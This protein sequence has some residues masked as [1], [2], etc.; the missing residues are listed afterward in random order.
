MNRRELLSSAAALL[1]G[2]RLRAAGAELATHPN[3]TIHQAREAGLKALKPTAGQIQRGLELHA[4]ALVFDAYAFAPRAAVDGPALARAVRAGASDAELQDLREEMSMTRCVTD[5]AERAEFQQAWEA[6][7]VTCI[8]QNAGEE[9][10]DPLRLLKRLA[11]FT[12]VTDSL[13]GFLMRAV[14]ADDVVAAKKQGKRC[15]YLTGNGVPLAQRWANVEE[16]LGCIRTFYQLGI[17][18]MHLTYNRRNML[19]D[20]CAEPADA[21]ISDLGRSAITEMNRV[22]VIV[23]VAHSGWRTSLQ[24]AKASTRPVV[25]SHTGCAAVHRHIRC[26]PDEVIK[27]IADSGGL[28]G[29]CCIPSF[30]GGGITAFLDHIDYVVRKFGVDHVAVGTDVVH[31]SRAVAKE[32]R[33]LPLAP[34]A[35]TRFE[36]LWPSD[37][38]NP[39]LAGDRTLA[40]TNWPLFTVGLVQRGYMDRDIEKIVGGNILRVARA[41]QVTK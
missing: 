19:G 22:G 13:R 40:W 30:L 18:M 7:G 20:G 16:E 25:A 6:A 17:R 41:V 15:L 4:N 29:I 37:A 11:R 32:A 9:G 1:T 21:G 39:A 14:T 8:F 23:D 38:F 33:E 3:E 28:V 24:A 35:R 34:K 2:A 27:A 26:K 31:S 10:Q 12:H 36:A 5:A